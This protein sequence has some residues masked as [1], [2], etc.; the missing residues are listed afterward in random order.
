[1]TDPHDHSHDHPDQDG[2]PHAWQHDGVRVVKAHQLDSNTA[3][4][5]GMSRRDRK[6]VV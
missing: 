2:Q 4:T 1:M 6:S 5:P 3:Q